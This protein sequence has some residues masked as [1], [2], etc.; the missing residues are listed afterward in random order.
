[1]NDDPISCPNC[2]LRGDMLE[3]GDE[4]EVEC[5]VC[6]WEYQVEGDGV[7]L[8]DGGLDP[9]GPF[10]MD[11]NE[12]E[13]DADGWRQVECTHCARRWPAE[14][15]V[16]VLAC[17]R[18]RHSIRVEDGEAVEPA[19]DLWEEYEPADDS[20][21]V[22]GET[23]CPGCNA[24]AFEDGPYCVP[25]ARG[26]LACEDCGWEFYDPVQ[27]A[28]WVER[29]HERYGMWGRARRERVVVAA[30][31]SGDFPDLERALAHLAD[32]GTLFIR[33][34]VYAGPVRIPYRSVT[35]QGDGPVDSIDF[36]SGMCI[37]GGTVVLRGITLRQ[38]LVVEQAVVRAEGCRFGGDDGPAVFVV[39][40]RS[41]VRLRDCRLADA[42]DEGLHVAGGAVVRLFAC[43]VENN[44]GGGV[45]VDNGSWIRL[46]DCDISRNGGSGIE[47]RHGS[48][49]FLRRCSIAENAGAGV[50]VRG[51]AVLSACE[52]RGQHGCG[53]LLGR[54]ARAV[55]RRCRVRDGRGDGMR[56]KRRARAVLHD[57]AWCGNAGS[58]LVVGAGVKLVLRRGR[59][60]GNGEFGGRLAA[61]AR[62]SLHECACAGNQRGN[63][64]LGAGAVIS[65]RSRVSSAARDGS[66]PPALPW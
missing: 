4:G 50:A 23:P 56:M 57:C 55:L 2:S 27:Y 30:D 63:W 54:R 49:V 22:E 28:E 12:A 31:G 58:G 21:W 33:P 34:G 47:A 61:T 59:L 19:E 11:E 32:G 15:G 65:V 38:P 24:G 3:R 7:V 53:V 40:H 6:G 60:E 66:G 36:L 8:D 1:M 29:M 42:P 16:D 26:W 41:R 18:C 13:P 35:L 25:L 9:D 43:R 46:Q 51:R 14:P 39:G 48:G 5:P 10:G 62:A 64:D 45:R 17:P 20:D 37:Q 52:I 44:A